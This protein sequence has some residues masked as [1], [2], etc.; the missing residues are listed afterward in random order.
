MSIYASQL[1]RLHTSH[2][3]RTCCRKQSSTPLPLFTKNILETPTKITT[4]IVPPGTF[5][6]GKSGKE[7][8][9]EMQ[10]KNAMGN[11][12]WDESYPFFNQGAARQI[13]RIAAALARMS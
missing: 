8:L 1:N 9:L 5:T 13:S 2:K 10:I 11:R 6:Q 7:K 3:R 4:H 12:M